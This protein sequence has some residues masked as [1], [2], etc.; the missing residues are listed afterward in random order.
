M[1]GLDPA[2]QAQSPPTEPERCSAETSKKTAWMAG[3][4]PAMTRFQE[5]AERSQLLRYPKILVAPM[6]YRVEDNLLY[7]IKEGG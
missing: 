7:L 2:I 1:A 3:S 5:N 4:S 6:L